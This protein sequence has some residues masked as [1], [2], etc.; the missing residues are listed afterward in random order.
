MCKR[1]CVSEI[2]INLKNT[3]KGDDTLFYVSHTCDAGSESV[4]KGT[5]PFIFLSLRGHIPYRYCHR[6]STHYGELM[7]A[8]YVL[9]THTHTHVRVKNIIFPEL[10]TCIGGSL[11]IRFRETIH[12]G[13]ARGMEKDV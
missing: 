13:G 3:H 1:K 4:L 10:E 2:L 8:Q 12:A 5:V 9:H 11:P 7:Y 6:Q